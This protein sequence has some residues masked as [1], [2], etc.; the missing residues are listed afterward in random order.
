MYLL[1]EDL[2]QGGAVCQLNEPYHVGDCPFQR[3]A[4]QDEPFLILLFCVLQGRVSRR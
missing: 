3:V 4:L 2:G 1:L